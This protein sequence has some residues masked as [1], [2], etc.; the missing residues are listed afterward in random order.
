MY[1]MMVIYKT[2]KQNTIL[3]GHFGYFKILMEPILELQKDSVTIQVMLIE[4]IH[5]MLWII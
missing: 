2:N 4:V 1:T 5:K 3:N